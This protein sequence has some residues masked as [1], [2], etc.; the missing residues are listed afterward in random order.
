MVENTE[1]DPEPKKAKVAAVSIG[2]ARRNLENPISGMRI[3]KLEE[4]DCDI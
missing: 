1:T 3:Y 4:M 2:L